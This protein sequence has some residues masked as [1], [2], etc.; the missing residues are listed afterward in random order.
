MVRKAKSSTE[1]GWVVCKAL[2][3]AHGLFPIVSIAHIV[4]DVRMACSSST[5]EILQYSVLEAVAESKVP[6]LLG[7]REQ[8]RLLTLL[9]TGNPAPI[10]G[11]QQMCEQNLFLKL[12]QPQNGI[13]PP[14]APPGTLSPVWFYSVETKER[15]KYNPPRSW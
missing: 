8:R 4:V 15:Q 3:R 14:Q 10:W 7:R 13:H 11:E 1:S 6:G 12:R 2:Y 5:S 9:L